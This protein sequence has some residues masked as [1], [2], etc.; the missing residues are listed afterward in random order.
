MHQAEEHA[1]PGL[2]VAAPGRDG[3]EK[4]HQE[5]QQNYPGPLQ[6]AI[7]RTPP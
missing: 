7:R 6:T 3:S 1:F 5:R 4:P 2:P